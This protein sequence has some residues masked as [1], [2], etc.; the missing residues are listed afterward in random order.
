LSNIVTESPVVNVSPGDLIYGSITSTCPVGTVSCASWDVLAVDLFT[1]DS[2]I[3]S[4]TPSEGQV[5]NW[6]FGGVLE[7]YFVISCDDY[8]PNRRVKFDR[9][10]VFDEYLRPIREPIWTDTFNS[11]AQPQC[12]YGVKAA[13]DDVRLQY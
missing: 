4:N 12:D 6:A 9:V 10:T 7:P 2:T 8:P 11:T 5:F 1:G 3:L 13:R